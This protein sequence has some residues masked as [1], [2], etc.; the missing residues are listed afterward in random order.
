MAEVLGKRNF[1]QASVDDN[2]VLTV[3]SNLGDLNNVSVA[4]PSTGDKL[5]W[6]GSAWVASSGG[7]T[8]GSESQ[9]AASDGES[10]TTSAT[11]QQKL[12]M[13]TGTLPAGTY[14]IGY[15]CQIKNSGS[16]Q[17]NWRVQVDDTTTIGS[18]QSND[19]SSPGYESGSG[20]WTGSLTN[21][22]HNI[23]F[24]FNSDGGTTSIKEVRLEIWRI[25]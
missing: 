14:R 7:G 13:T 18:G 21:A 22:T 24:D 15:S 6:N 19:S 17:G 23:D 5:E 2:N 12:R 16:T 10:T 20:F 25:S 8:F 9:N 1:D 11:Y 3:A 4:S